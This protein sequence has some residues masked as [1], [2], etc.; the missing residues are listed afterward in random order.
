MFELVEKEDASGSIAG[1]DY[2]SQVR[3]MIRSPTHVMFNAHGCQLWNRNNIG[4]WNNLKNVFRGRPTKAQY[5]S[6]RDFIDEV[7]GAGATDQVLEAWKSHKTV[8]VSGGGE[9]LPLPRRLRAVL[10]KQ[11]Y[12]AVKPDWKADLSATLKACKQCSKSLRI[13]TDNHHLGLEIKPDHPRTPEDCQR[14]TNHPVVAVHGYGNNLKKHL[15]LISRFET[16][17]GES[18][19]DEV[20]CT[21]KCAALYGRRAAAELD[22]LPPGGTVAPPPYRERHITN[23][24]TQVEKY[25]DLPNGTRIKV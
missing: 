12:D 8:L 10:T 24:Y 14:L 18:Y 25:F 1:S 3:V 20:F 5:E 9:A 21:E 2:G 6:R 11:A 16:W 23:H 4:G 19:L 15:G 7:F 17:D 13:D 22:P